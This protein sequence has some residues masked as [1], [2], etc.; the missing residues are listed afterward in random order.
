MDLGDQK[1]MSEG[2]SRRGPKGQKHKMKIRLVVEG[3]FR[4]EAASQECRSGVREGEDTG[5]ADTA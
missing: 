5:P 4:L 1:Q 2:P 3:G